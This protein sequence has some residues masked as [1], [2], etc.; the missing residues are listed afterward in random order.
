M[1]SEKDAALGFSRVLDAYD[2]Y[3]K[4]TEAKNEKPL[5]ILAYI[6]EMFQ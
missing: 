6:V 1:F 2:H 5:S 3:V 4:R